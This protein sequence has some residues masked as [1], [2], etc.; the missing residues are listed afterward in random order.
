MVLDDPLGKQSSLGKVLSIAKLG[1]M[2]ARGNEVGK[3]IKL[4][5]SSWEIYCSKLCE[6]L[7]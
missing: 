5:S 2:Y 1:K 6:S 7:G 4:V 3:L